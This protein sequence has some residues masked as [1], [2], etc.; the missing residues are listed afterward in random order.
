MSTGERT[1]SRP[2]EESAPIE[3]RFGEYGG[4]YVFGPNPRAFG[5]LPISPSDQA[6]SNGSR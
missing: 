4:Q 3:H 2:E 6:A 5:A 1:G